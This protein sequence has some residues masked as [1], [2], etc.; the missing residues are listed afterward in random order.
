MVAELCNRVLHSVVVAAL[1]MANLRRQ[2][3]IVQN[4]AIVCLHSVVVAA[5]YMANLR[6]Q[7][8]IV[9]NCAIVC[10]H[11]VVVAA[12]V[13]RQPTPASRY[14]ANTVQSS[15]STL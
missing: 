5:L 12:T 14:S 2:V 3:T 9:Q 8:A 7:V 10:L 6:R 4:C 13:H 11:S 15:V 1:C